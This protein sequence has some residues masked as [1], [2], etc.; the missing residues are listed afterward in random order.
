MKKK[1]HFSDKMMFFLMMFYF[2]FVSNK[3]VIHKIENLEIDYIFLK[4]EELDKYRFQNLWI[5]SVI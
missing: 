4:V 5:K 2:K 1:K 3:F